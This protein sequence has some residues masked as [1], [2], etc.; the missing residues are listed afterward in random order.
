MSSSQNPVTSER[1]LAML[2][3]ALGTDIVTALDDPE[4]IEIMV[5]PDGKLWL[6]KL[7]AGMIDT[8][9][10]VAPEQAE[11][12]VRLVGTHINQDVTT[13]NPIVSAELPGNGNALRGFCPPLFPP[14]LFLFAKVPSLSSNLLIMSKLAP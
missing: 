12:V 10:L 9:V 6:D 11:R 13:D 2:R 14:P 7:G 3:T 5:N 1:T 4:V 8:K